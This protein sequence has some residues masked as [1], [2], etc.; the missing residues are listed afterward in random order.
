MSSAPNV[1]CTL[2]WVCSRRKM[3]GFCCA[4]CQ[5]RDTCQDACEN[6]PEHCM[7]ARELTCREIA[8]AHGIKHIKHLSALRKIENTGK[9]LGMF[10][11]NNSCGA[12]AMDNRTGNPVV[13]ERFGSVEEAILWL[14]ARAE[15]DQKGV[16]HEG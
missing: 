14:A 7:M 10:Y 16:D 11:N 4:V 1:K 8:N 13:S 6:N 15:A 9:P 5:I 3:A 2:T 12:I